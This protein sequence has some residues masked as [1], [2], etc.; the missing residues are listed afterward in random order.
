VRRELKELK[1]ELAELRAA[2]DRVGPSH[3]E[4]KIVDR[5]VELQHREETMWR[6]RSRIQWLSEGDKNTRFFHMRANGRKKKNRVS[7]LK[8][9]DGSYT[10]DQHEL[11][12]MARNFYSNLYTTEGTAGMEEVLNSVPVSVTQAMNDQL[13]AGFE[14]T[15]VKQALFQMY[16]LK[17]PAQMVTP[18]NS[19]R[20]TGPH[21]A[22]RLL[23]LCSESCGGRIVL[24]G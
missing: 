22:M 15:E 5:I 23:E 9:P 16:P 14:D 20:S 11:G 18:P 1:L 10:E 17:A 7:R 3:R 4:I 21:V 24:L 12:Q 2:P 13:M 8:R 19:F 6:Q